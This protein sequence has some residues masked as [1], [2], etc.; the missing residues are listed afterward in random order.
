ML[1]REENKQK[2]NSYLPH[3]FYKEHRTSVEDPKSMVKKP[4][5]LMLIALETDAQ[6]AETLY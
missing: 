1:S 4:K 5:Y 3:L 2:R 6:E